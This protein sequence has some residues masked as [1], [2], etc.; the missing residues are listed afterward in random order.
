MR[1]LCVCHTRLFIVIIAQKFK[2]S[3]YF[4][5]VQKIARVKFSIWIIL[6]FHSLFLCVFF[7]FYC[8]RFL[9]SQFLPECFIDDMANNMY[10]YRFCVF[11]KFKVH[12]E[13][14]KIIASSETGSLNIFRRIAYL[15]V[16]YPINANYIGGVL[17]KWWSRCYLIAQRNQHSQKNNEENSSFHWVKLE[18][19]TDF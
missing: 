14:C 4:Y 3:V 13:G 2:F 15:P 19:F 1:K 6:I 16:L 11:V 9:A 8:V 17:Y 5:I 7:T 12:A 18:N 10:N